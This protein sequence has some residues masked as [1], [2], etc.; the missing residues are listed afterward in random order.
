MIVKN[1][2]KIPSF[3]SKAWKFSHETTQLEETVISNFSAFL[4]IN[5]LEAMSWV[6][7]DRFGEIKMKN[8]ISSSLLTSSKSNKQMQ[9][10]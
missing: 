7:F 3:L 5:K 2:F 6:R 1:T 9:L 8:L 4:Q 10:V